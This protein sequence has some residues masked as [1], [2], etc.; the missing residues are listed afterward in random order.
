MK[1]EEQDLGI[2]EPHLAATV[3]T[4]KSLKETPPEP[5]HVI[6]LGAGVQSSTM[7]LMAAHGEITP[8]PVAAIFADTQAE[9]K[10]VY[11][12]LDE[13]EPL[14]PFP[15]IR[16]TGGNL[17][18]YLTTPYWSK[19]N[20]KW[21]VYG[22]PAFTKNPDGSQGHMSRQCT[23]DYKV[24]PIDKAIT[25]QMRKAGVKTSIKWLGISLDEIVRMKPSRRSTVT[26][27]WPLIDARMRRHDCLEWIK[28]HGYPTPPRS[29]C[30]FCP[31][32][33]NAEWRSL[34]EEEF[35]EVGGFE[36]RVQQAHAHCSATAVPF[37]H[38]SMVPI[39]EA[40]LSTDEER[41]QGVMFGNECEGMC[42]V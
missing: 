1:K 27:R 37:L 34:S 12:W 39:H 15:V 17:E 8:M 13:I 18:E 20:Q 30:T 31:Y 2:K 29:A 4:Q 21:S 22:F 3:E 7:A 26:H 40:D 24:A 6:S 28:K 41:G 35:A 10:A 16:V 25:A 33:S 38:R 14:L 42:G 23:T 19:K 36:F 11:E 9:P 32:R 5:I